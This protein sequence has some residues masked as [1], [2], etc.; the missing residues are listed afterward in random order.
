MHV[1]FRKKK[2][3]KGEKN[4]ENEGD[5]EKAQLGEYPLK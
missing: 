5:E 2:R 3:K 1:T 4:E